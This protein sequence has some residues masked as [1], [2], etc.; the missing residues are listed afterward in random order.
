MPPLERPTPLPRTTERSFQAGDILAHRLAPLEHGDP[1]IQYLTRWED[2]E[3]L[4]FEP[5]SSFHAAEGA[6][7]LHRYIDS[8]GFEVDF[9]VDL[10]QFAKDNPRS[11]DMPGSPLD[12][13][14]EINAADI[15][16]SIELI[17]ELAQLDID[18]PSVPT[19]SE[20]ASFQEIQQSAG[21]V[22]PRDTSSIAQ[23]LSRRTALSAAA[24]LHYVCL[25]CAF[26]APIPGMTTITPTTHHEAMAS[27]ER[28]FWIAAEEAELVSMR[29]K[30]VWSLVDKRPNKGGR[31][32]GVRCVGTKW[33]Y[34]IKYKNGNVD[35]FKARLVAQGFLQI[36]GIDCGDTFSP[37]PRM[38]TL[39]I[40]LALL[41]NA[42]DSDG[43]WVGEQCD[44]STAFLYADADAETYCRQ[45]PGYAE[46]G[47]EQWILRLRKSLYG[48]KP[49]SRAWHNEI[50]TTL[51]DIG[52]VQ[53][54]HD[55]CLFTKRQGTSV[56]HLIVYVDDIAFFHNDQAMMDGI[57]RKLTSKY[58]FSSRGPLE[59]YI[60][61]KIQH[62]TEGVQLSQT[63]YINDLIVRFGLQ[64]H[65]SGHI[66]T[67]SLVR[68]AQIA[69]PVS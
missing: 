20:Y 64:H 54:V 13:L 58:T 21:V 37:T 5:A 38:A 4:T 66:L 26:P 7:I 14:D 25:A 10:L 11:E 28:A 6:A 33:V 8:G 27:P 65:K 31:V 59:W 23:R 69:Y 32:D 52:F 2:D 67:P 1:T 22:D 46:P 16:D 62:T 30:G 55:L 3:A 9:D 24:F 45:P 63:D 56:I 12:L 19:P 39:K 49:A 53:S 61:I 34:K 68:R 18:D 35:K 60:G 43:V 15:D 41:A 42:D 44:I 47:K 48:T 57:Y 36:P 40:C 17:D 50:R 51:V 29:D